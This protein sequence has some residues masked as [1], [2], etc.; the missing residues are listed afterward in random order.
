[1]GV[2]LKFLKQ[3]RCGPKS[4]CIIQYIQLQYWS[5]NSIRGKIQGITTLTLIR[6]ALSALV[7]PPPPPAL[8]S[9]VLSL[10]LS[11]HLH[12]PAHCTVSCQNPPPCL[13]PSPLE[14]GSRQWGDRHNSPW[15]TTSTVGDCPL[16]CLCGTTPESHAKLSHDHSN[17]DLYAAS[18]GWH[19]DSNIMHLKLANVS[20]SCS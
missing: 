7:V 19:P 15:H 20:K 18:S 5:P 2:C 12:S 10:S 16:L 4:F 1:M 9:P 13:Y 17:S 14:H 6:G 11:C 3:V 8:S